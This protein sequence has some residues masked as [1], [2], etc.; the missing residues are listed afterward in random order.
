MGANDNVEEA[1]HAYDR[2]EPDQEECHTAD[3]CNLDV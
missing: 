2:N 3:F 1:K